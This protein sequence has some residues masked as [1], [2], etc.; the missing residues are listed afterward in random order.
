MEANPIGVTP[1]LIAALLDNFRVGAI[2]L[3]GFILLFAWKRHGMAP[4]GAMIDVLMDATVISGALEIFS[5][6]FRFGF[7]L[8]LT[9]DEHIMMVIGTFALSVVLGK[10]LTWNFFIAWKGHPPRKSGIHT[11]DAWTEE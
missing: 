5:H 6:I 8:V 3:V 11:E 4:L 7:A 10:R 9:P 2:V 1:P